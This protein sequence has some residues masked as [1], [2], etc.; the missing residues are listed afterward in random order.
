MKAH[1][2]TADLSNKA[3]IDSVC[4]KVR[5][6]VGDVSILI[7]NAGIVGGKNFLDLDDGKFVVIG[8][9]NVIN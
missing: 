6:E 9:S 5:A 8:Q 7:N 1:A 4:A 2:Y 3:Q